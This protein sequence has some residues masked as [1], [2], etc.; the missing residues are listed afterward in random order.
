MNLL[1]ARSRCR[2][3]AL[4]VTA[5]SG[6]VS[7]APAGAQ[8]LE[9]IVVTAQKRTESAQDVAATISVVDS[10]QL[11]ALRIEQPVDLANAVPGLSTYNATSGGTPLFAIR[12]IGMDDFNPNNASGVGTYIDD[13]YASFPAFLNGQIFDVERVEVLE[14]PQGTL[15]GKNATGGAINFISRKPTDETTGYF[16]VSY[17][18]WNSVDLKAAVGG[19]LT[20][21]LTGRIA[22]TWTGQG[23]GY[24]TDIETGHRYGKPNRGALRGQLEFKPTSD[25][26]ALLNVHL[27]RDESRP[28]VPQTYGNEALLP[29]AAKGL[30]DT[31]STDPSVVRVGN[32]ISPKLN[33]RGSGLSLALTYDAGEFMLNSTTGYDHF[34]YRTVDDNSGTDGPTYW[35][36][37]DDVMD[38]VY[39][40]LRATSKRG[41]FGGLIDWVVGT[42][43]SR[44]TIHGMDSS[45]QSAPFVGEFLDPP[46][47]LEPGLNTVQANYI[48]T[49][50]SFG[51]F[52]HSETH[53]TD[54]LSFVL[55]GRYSHDRLD[56]NGVTTE[57]GTDAT[58]IP[59]IYGNVVTAL[60]QVHNEQNFSYQT[61]LN[62]KL[63][64]HV[65]LYGTVSTSYKAGAT[66]A[67]PALDP[68]AWGYVSPEHV[69]AFETGEKSTLID[70]RLQINGSY[71]HYDYTDRQS[72][73]DFVSPLTG[74]FVSSLANIPKSEVDG[75]EVDTSVSPLDGWQLSGSATYL[76]ARVTESLL[77]VRGAPLLLAVPDGTPLSLSPRWTFLART[78]YERPISATLK[79]SA[80]LDYSWRDDQSS[81]L[82]DPN[83]VSGVQKLL[84]ASVTVGRIA[85]GLSVSLWGRNLTNANFSTYQ[86]TSFYGGTTTYRELPRTYGLEVR[87]E[88]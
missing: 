50:N 68:A 18:R 36:F 16:D 7:F 29:P 43:F 17:G 10:K 9:Q 82:G 56:F 1:R 37:Q 81:Q 62:Y 23:E 31:P 38:Q 45:D 11:D 74:A 34:D 59:V 25:F 3:I 27:S 58:A 53:L 75:V 51:I 83:A 40:E 88:F 65:L 78:S 87:D 6:A 33:E 86:F 2:V 13:V 22:G 57:G 73:V 12:G 39:E 41:L 70:G 49:R 76:D 26:T 71:F 84:G 30:I 55:G 77:N 47:F 8:E 28:P 72:L 21:T 63:F 32:L 54:Q 20:D 48:Q 64:P 15:Y 80:Q 44:D 66:Y 52:L 5:A 14:G 24:Q 19:R 69:L 35:F 61:G 42:S 79:A 60:D 46:N 67:S 4:A 85:K